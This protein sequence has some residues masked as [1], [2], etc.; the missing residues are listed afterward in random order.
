[1]LIAP[2]EAPPHCWTSQHLPSKVCFWVTEVLGCSSF[3]L[4]A[5][6][7]PLNF[8]LKLL[9]GVGPAGLGMDHST[10]DDLCQVNSSRR[11]QHMGHGHESCSGK[12]ISPTCLR[13]HGMPHVAWHTL[14]PVPL[15]SIPQW[16]VPCPAP[17]RG[18]HRLG[19]DNAQTFQWMGALSPLS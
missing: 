7:E 5:G 10:N 4:P 2:L 17:R 15:V 9:V 16:G 1:M 11:A 12:N 18:G 13:Q 14:S 6:S 8:L 19:Q 3:S